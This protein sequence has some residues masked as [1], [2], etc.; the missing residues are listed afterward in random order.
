MDSQPTA[1]VSPR[2]PT[3]RRRLVTVAATIA[4]GLALTGLIVGAAVSQ[5]N[6][7]ATVTATPAPPPQQPATETANP[8]TPGELTSSAESVAQQQAAALLNGDEQ[9]WMAPVDP[10]QPQLQAYY[11]RL[12]TNLRGL[13]VTYVNYRYAGSADLPARATSGTINLYLGFC[14]TDSC[15]PPRGAVLNYPKITQSVTW[16]WNGKHWIITKAG[17]GSQREQIQPTP[18]EDTDLVFAQGRRI[19]VAAAR[20]GKYQPGKLVTAADRAARHADTYAAAMR[21]PQRHYRVYLADERQW[22]RWFRPSI[23]SG[24]I[25]YALPLQDIDTE[26]VLRMASLGSPAKFSEVLRHELG[27][28]VTLSGTDRRSDYLYDGDMWL[29]EGI[30]EYIAH[31][32]KPAAT[33]DRRASTA[34]VVRSRFRPRTMVFEPLDDKIESGRVTDAYYG[35]G[36][37]A[38]DCMAT[39]YG[40]AKM[41]EFFRLHIRGAPRDP[42]VFDPLGTRG[43]LDYDQASRRTFGTGFRTVDK[44]CVTWIRRQIG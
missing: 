44:T 43:K 40:E 23:R 26:V 9:G 18:W 37:F 7:D 32:P 39:V 21:N 31:A 29:T 12:Y 14:F 2:S 25:G 42:G 1:D 8:A 41:L 19:T 36:H 5:L 10:K 3:G 35:L 28:V 17:P 30:A 20:G 4:T 34:V 24:V 16:A 15:E 11:R 6:P 27:H 13:Q 33:S 38:V 22:K